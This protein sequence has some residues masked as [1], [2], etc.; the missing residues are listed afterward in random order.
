MNGQ[1]FTEVPVFPFRELAS[2]V[3][4]PKPPDWMASIATLF[5][6]VFSILLSVLRL[7]FAGW[8]LH[9]IGYAVGFSRRT[10]EWM[11]FSVFLGW[12]FKLLILRSGGLKS[13]RRCLPLFLGF[14]LGE[15]SMGVI[16]GIVGTVNP[17]A[18]GYQ[19]YP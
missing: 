10:I 13:Y 4:S 7:R 14:I 12:L 2:Y 9:P 5:G 3:T 16:Y 11:W 17:A 6:F 19:L 15:F 8:P 18:Q 1:R